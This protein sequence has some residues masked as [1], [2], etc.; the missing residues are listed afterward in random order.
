MT[1]TDNPQFF[2]MHSAALSKYLVCILMDSSTHLHGPEHFAQCILFGL[3]HCT[4]WNH[5]QNFVFHFTVLKG[6]MSLLCV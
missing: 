2:F 3:E 4:P 1:V 6:I 5:R